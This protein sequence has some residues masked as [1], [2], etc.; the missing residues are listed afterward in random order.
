MGRL[1]KTTSTD[2]RHLDYID[3][4]RGYAIL[5]V[6]ALHSATLIPSL[7][8]P[9]HLLAAQG[10]RGVQLFFVVSALTLT[11]SW[12]SRAEGAGAFYVRRVFRI[13]PMFWVAIAFYVLVDIPAVQYLGLHVGNGDVC[14]RTSSRDHRE[15]CAGRLERRR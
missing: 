11:L 14:F 7:E 8:W 5:A 9:F 2:I 4:L 3:A 13:V 12:H 15:H 10:A 1:P 6:I